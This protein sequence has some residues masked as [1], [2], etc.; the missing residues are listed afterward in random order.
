VLLLGLVRQKKWARYVLAPAG[1]E[2]LVSRLVA[3]G[4]T[5]F[6]NSGGFWAVLQ[7]DKLS[8]YLQAAGVGAP[9]VLNDP[10]AVL[11]VVS[12]SGEPVAGPITVAVWGL[13]SV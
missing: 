8:Q 10:G 11:G 7:P 13:D 12:A 3:Q 4:A 2:P 6:A 1:S 9:A 5:A